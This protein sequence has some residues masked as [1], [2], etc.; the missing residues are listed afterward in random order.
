MKQFIP[1]LL[2]IMAF[3]SCNDN[4]TITITNP[5]VEQQ[6]HEQPL[7]TAHPRFSWNYGTDRRSDEE[8]QTIESE[9]MQQNYRI[10]VATT[11]ENAQKGI[12]ASGIQG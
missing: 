6:F 5:N 12:G 7:A 8:K 9:V 4:L 1:F 10:I 3:T 2:A 11:A